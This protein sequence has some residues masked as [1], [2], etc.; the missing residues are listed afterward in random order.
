[1]NS[2]FQ[3]A[4]SL[5][6]PTKSSQTLQVLGFGISHLGHRTLAIFHKC[7]IIHGVAT[8]TSKSRGTFHFSISSIK[9]NQPTFTAQAFSKSFE[10]TL[11]VKAHILGTFQL[12]FGRVIV[13]LI[14]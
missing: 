6:T 8:Q 14:I 3:A 4:I 9:S 7:L 2:N 12:P 1:L 5:T 10:E 13:V 11:S